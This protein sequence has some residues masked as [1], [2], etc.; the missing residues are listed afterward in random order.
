[1]LGEPDAPES[2]YSECATL[3]SQGGAAMWYDATSAVSVIEDPASSKVAGR[4][5]YACGAGWRTR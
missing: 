4:N 1:M 5:G 3:Y 2:G